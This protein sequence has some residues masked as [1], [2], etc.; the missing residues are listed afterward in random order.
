MIGQ[1]GGQPSPELQA[2]EDPVA[3][4][5]PVLLDIRGLGLHHQAGHI[6]SRGA[7]RAAE[8]A[9]DAEVRVRLHLVGAPEPGI[10]RPGR[11]LPDEVRLRPGR[12]RFRPECPEAGAHPLLR[13]EGP[14]GPATMAGGCHLQHRQVGPDQDRLDPAGEFEAD[15]AGPGRSEVESAGIVAFRSVDVGSGPLADDDVAPVVP[16]SSRR[17]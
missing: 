5:H 12:R 17:S 11:D 7:L 10:D 1:A 16:A 8:L 9:V 15:E 4:R 13:I 3:R 6:H 14:T 2:G